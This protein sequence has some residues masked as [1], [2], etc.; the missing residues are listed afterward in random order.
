MPENTRLVVVMTGLQAA[1]RAR[2]KPRQAFPGGFARILR[3]VRAMAGTL[4]ER[5]GPARRAVMRLWEI[6]SAGPGIIRAAPIRSNRNRYRGEPPLGTRERRLF[7][8][9]CAGAYAVTLR[10]RALISLRGDAGLGV[11]FLVSGPF[12][13]RER[14]KLLRRHRR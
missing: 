10:F 2:G 3:H 1:Y 9:G 6:R 13:Y 4:P 5:H 14:G 7:M 8:R 11:D 12:G